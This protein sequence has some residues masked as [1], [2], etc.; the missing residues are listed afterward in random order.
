MDEPHEIES[1]LG[2]AAA[3]ML[4][5]YLTACIYIAR[6]RATAPVCTDRAARTCLSL[7]AESNRRLCH[8]NSTR[9]SA[10]IKPRLVLPLNFTL[11]FTRNVEPGV[12]TRAH[13]LTYRRRWKRICLTIHPIPARATR[14]A[15]TQIILRHPGRTQRRPIRRTRPQVSLAMERHGHI[16]HIAT[17]LTHSSSNNNNSNNSNSQQP[18]R[19]RNLWRRPPH[20]RAPPL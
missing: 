12:T 8:C 3:D 1:G 16:K 19:P 4:Y 13:Y 5:I 14:T 9:S 17:T 18:R 6:R 2:T 11:L 7:Q 20:F 15:H 10:T